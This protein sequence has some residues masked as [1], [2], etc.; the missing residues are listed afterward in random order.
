MSTNISAADFSYDLPERNEGAAY[1]K[2]NFPA[3]YV[4][5]ERPVAGRFMTT[6]DKGEPVPYHVFMLHGGGYIMEAMTMH[7][8]KVKAFA[9]RGLRVTAFAYPLAPEND[10]DT[11]H[12]A[13]E[14]AYNM[15]RAL[16]PDDK[17]AVYGDSAG[18]GLGLNLLMRLRDKGVADRPMKSVWASPAVD[19]SMTNPDILKYAD[20]DKSL[21]YDEEKKLVTVLCGENDPKEVRYSPLYGDLSDL[22]DM[23]MFYG[24]GEILRPDCE[25]FAEKVKTVEGT[26]VKSVMAPERF[27]DYLMMV[28]YGYVEAIEAFD[29]IKEFLK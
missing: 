10:M 9:D 28:A 22:G 12:D 19:L 23:L 8:D 3:P 25:V 4:A 21:N 2:E 15:I 17:F 26:T 20:T 5:V 7:T 13:V 1:R 6:V 29:M 27:H 24:G 16:Y 18:G 14:E 11:I